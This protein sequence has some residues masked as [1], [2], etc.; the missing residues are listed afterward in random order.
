MHFAPRDKS[1]S[2]SKYHVCGAVEEQG[3]GDL[4]DQCV[5]AH[6]TISGTKGLHV[7]KVIIC[8]ED[9]ECSITN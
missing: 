9:D 4:R 7:M 6:F 3:H 5:R 2:S 8:D 1:G